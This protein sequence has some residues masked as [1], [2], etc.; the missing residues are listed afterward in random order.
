MGVETLERKVELILKKLE[1]IEEILF[2][3]DDEP[4][5][6]ELL[7]IKRYLEKKKEGKTDLIPLEEAL[8]EI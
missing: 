5:E 1:R 2:I 6:D 7:A 3:E 8:N 4:L